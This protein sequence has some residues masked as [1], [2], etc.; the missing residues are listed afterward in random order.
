MN[1]QKKLNIYSSIT[2]FD[3]GFNVA[4]HYECHRAI[5]YCKGKCNRYDG[6]LHPARG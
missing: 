1:Y 4:L 5:P 6:R 2:F 3:M